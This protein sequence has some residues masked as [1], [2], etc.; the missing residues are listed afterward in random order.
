MVDASKDMELY[1]ES[2]SKNLKEWYVLATKARKQGK[3]PEQKVD[4]TLAN[5]MAERVEGLV[6]VIAPQLANSN[7]TKRLHE[8]EK[9]YP[10]QSWEIALLIAVEVAKEKF[11]KFKDKKESI[12]MGIRVGMAYS[13]AGIVAAPLEGFVEAHIKKGEMGKNI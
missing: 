1:F 4:I 9:K 12:E 2:I 3:D 6:S 5:S 10:P 13:T 11:C 7:M 8:L